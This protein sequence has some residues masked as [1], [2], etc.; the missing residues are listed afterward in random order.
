MA[1]GK[2]RG[3]RAGLWETLTEDT[4]NSKSSFLA[5]LTEPRMAVL[6][7][8]GLGCRCVSRLAAGN[9]YDVELVAMDTDLDALANCLAH[10][11]ILLGEQT[12]GGQG[13]A[14]EPIIGK[15]AAMESAEEVRKSC[16][17]MD[18]VVL[19]CGLEGGTGAGAAPV[20]ADLAR[21]DGA[22]VLGVV[23]AQVHASGLENAG[24]ETPFG[25]LL[26]GVQ[27]LIS[28]AP[29]VTD[30][31]S[32]A[33]LAEM[34]TA[35]TAFVQ[36]L[37]PHAGETSPLLEA[38]RQEAFGPAVALVAEVESTRQQPAL[39]GVL[40]PELVAG[41]G[42]KTGKVLLNL[43]G[44]DQ[45]LCQVLEKAAAAA[46]TA[47][48]EHVQVV[49]SHRRC[50]GRALRVVL[51]AWGVAATATE[52]EPSSS[53]TAKED[54][55][56][57][58]EQEV[59]FDVREPAFAIQYGGLD[60]GDPEP[61]S[62]SGDDEPHSFARQLGKAVDALLRDEGEPAVATLMRLC[63]AAEA[64]GGQLPPMTELL[65]A[66]GE[67]VSCAAQGGHRLSRQEKAL[68]GRVPAIVAALSLELDTALEA[69]RE[70][71]AEIEALCSEK[72]PLPPRPDEVPEELFAEGSALELLAV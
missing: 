12:A 3:D 25:R 32:T 14:A 4:E 58:G 46:R 42:E 61:E 29:M 36:A 52:Q 17:G 56:W 7:V 57:P 33:V 54:G 2:E 44:A 43:E 28:V 9:P 5:Y 22:V 11:K 65:R 67:L 15:A 8:G 70:L 26:E 72:E 23:P 71:A 38:L 21:G 27:V 18:E 69:A 49:A 31:S 51:V 50:E 45:N 24:P 66:V 35:L 10:R 59:L 39:G 60:T 1:A 62:R 13:A 16:R 40:V 30:L 6:G 41:L 55:A 19:V 53:A 37:Q 68:L 48:P 34:D 47:L 20:I 63:E 64:Q